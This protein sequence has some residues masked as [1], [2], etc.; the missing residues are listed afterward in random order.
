[1]ATVGASHQLTGLLNSP[2]SVRPHRAASTAPDRVVPRT[3]PRHPPNKQR[4]AEI[5]A[6]LR[7]AFATC[8]IEEPADPNG[9]IEEEAGAG[10]WL[11]GSGPAAHY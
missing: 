6:L 7:Q 4:L 2:Q 10:M 8:D 3:G 9:R 11:P 1:M 5:A